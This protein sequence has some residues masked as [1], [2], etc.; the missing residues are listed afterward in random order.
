MKP[1]F[2]LL[3]LVP[4]AVVVPNTQQDEDAPTADQLVMR[5]FRPR[6]I[7]CDDLYRAAQQTLSRSI[8][9]K[10]SVAGGGAN[11]NVALNV[12]KFR[13]DQKKDQQKKHHI[14]DWSDVRFNR[15][16]RRSFDFHRVL[17]F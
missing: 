2:S 6:H 11:L 15:F 13:C 7:D 14:D 16:F 3:A 5:Q 4:L 9:V 12:R 17:G 10:D 8:F 1:L